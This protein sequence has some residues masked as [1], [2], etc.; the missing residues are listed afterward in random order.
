[1]RA[2]VIWGLALGATLA[3]SAVLTA[4]A[5]AWSANTNKDASAVWQKVQASSAKLDGLIKGK[6]LAAV[7]QVAFQVRDLVN[8]LPAKSKSLSPANRAKLA[9]GVKS[10]GEIAKLL[11]KYGDANDQ[12]KTEAQNKR[13]QTVLHAIE[14]LYPKGTLKASMHGAS[15]HHGAGD[16]KPHKDENHKSHKH[17]DH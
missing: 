12:A 13:L 8:T 17:G 11:D 14:H 2:R 10:V 4:G 6:K 1:M 7:H 9:T 5:P 3:V 15:G 16:H